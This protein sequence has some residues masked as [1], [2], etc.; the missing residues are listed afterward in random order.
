MYFNVPLKVST[1]GLVELDPNESSSMSSF[2]ESYSSPGSKEKESPPQKG[3]EPS[4]YNSSGQI[5]RKLTGMK[6]HDG[7]TSPERRRSG[8]DNNLSYG[9]SKF[10]R[11]RGEL[12]RRQTESSPGLAKIIRAVDLRKTLRGSNHKLLEKRNLRS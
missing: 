1:A 7:A 10:V 5:L 9:S 2:G 6:L 11:R 12:K 4:S 8:S 3:K